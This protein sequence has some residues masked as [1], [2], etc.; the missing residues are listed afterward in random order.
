MKKR[1]KSIKEGRITP[2]REVIELDIV[3]DANASSRVIQKFFT[4]EF[5]KSYNYL[6][7]SFLFQQRDEV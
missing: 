7:R 5:G 4:E 2:E 6:L 3:E 1:F